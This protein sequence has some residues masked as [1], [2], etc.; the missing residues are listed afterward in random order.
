MRRCRPV[1][2]S[3][4]IP[5]ALAVAAGLALLS[6]ASCGG[7]G[8][9]GC[10]IGQER[11]C[12]CPGGRSSTQVCFP[13]GTWAACVCGTPPEDAWTGTDV[14]VG[15]DVGG[16]DVP[17]RDDGPGTDDGAD[18]G[19][20][21]TPQVRQGC[22]ADG[23]VHWFDTCGGEGDLVQ[24]C[25]GRLS[26]VP[27]DEG[28]AA[29]ADY[30]QAQRCWTPEPTGQAACF[31][32]TSEAPCT[33]FPCNEDG[34][35]AFCGQDAQYAGAARTFQ[36]LD[37]TGAVE[38]PC[39]ETADSGETVVDF[40][41]GLAWQRTWNDAKNWQEA[42]EY[43]D[44]L[45]YGGQQDW[46]LPSYAELAGLVDSGRHDPAIDPAFPG[47]PPS[48]FWTAS[49]RASE[50]AR[51]WTVDFALGAIGG[52]Y[53][54]EDHNVRC[55]RGS[56]WHGSA[57][58]RFS[59]SADPTG[60]AVLDRA[61]GLAWQGQGFAARPWQDALEYCEWLTC[62][63]RGDWRLPDASELRSLVDVAASAPASGFPGLPDYAGTPVDGRHWSSTS[64]SY[65]PEYDGNY[66]LIT[67]ARAWTVDF[68]SGDVAHDGKG[69][70]H[71][72]RCVRDGL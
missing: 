18:T 17:G 15:K 38:A 61:T 16:D 36:C 34:S 48:A 49:T 26:C 46:R 42:K 47:T 58:G 27:K 4:R 68:R 64:V 54:E 20:V 7:D 63:G 9:S 13:A 11:S 60:E 14:P 28:T 66:Q 40:L 32:G 24:A 10:T 23:N 62:A 2:T 25:V 30:C 21:P 1:P 44:G 69:A 6:L 41:T 67:G 12:S 71:P 5:V 70:E 33:A 35:P 59:T 8:S 22:G 37:A 57:E 19:C 52:A 55:V 31:N 45:T 43:C 3:L 72:G 39:D 56:P 65:F 51:A 50:P 29:C 53:Q